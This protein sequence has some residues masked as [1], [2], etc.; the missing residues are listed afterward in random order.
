[1]KNPKPP[2]KIPRLNKKVK[3]TRKIRGEFKV[4]CD[5]DKYWKFH[6]HWGKCNMTRISNVTKKVIPFIH[7]QKN[8][9]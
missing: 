8:A 9:F 6:I 3:I 7:L 1:M 2:I 5:Y 4:T